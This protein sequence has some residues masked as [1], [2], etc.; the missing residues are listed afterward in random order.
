[1]EWILGSLPEIYLIQY[2]T[3]L[4]HKII[5]IILGCFMVMLAVTDILSLGALQ[6]FILTI[7]PQYILVRA[8]RQNHLQLRRS[9]LFY[10]FRRLFC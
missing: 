4:V 8:A 2:W 9:L 7:T 5:F 3:C 10:S 6:P 1:M